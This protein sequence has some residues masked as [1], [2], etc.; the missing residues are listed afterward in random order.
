MNI[1]SALL[2]WKRREKAVSEWQTCE[3]EKACYSSACLPPSARDHKDH[4]PLNSHGVVDDLSEVPEDEVV[5][6]P[7][8]GK[9]WHYL[10]DLRHPCHGWG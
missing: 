9:L 6:L 10:D 1:R 5:Q 8:C 4:E 3:L 2:E 7:P